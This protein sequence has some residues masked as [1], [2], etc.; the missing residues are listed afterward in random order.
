[1]AATARCRS[2]AVHNGTALSSK[3][4]QCPFYIQGRRLNTD[5]LNGISYTRPFSVYTTNCMSASQHPVKS[6]A[7]MKLN[8]PYLCSVYYIIIVRQL[9][10]IDS[11]SRGLSA[12][13][14]V[15][16][17]DVLVQAMCLFV[18]FSAR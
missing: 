16:V 3:C 4:E 5:L 13:S 1:M 8:L 10:W 17:E 6:D 7:S 14:D 15:D 2:S 12:I 18:S 11:T 9:F